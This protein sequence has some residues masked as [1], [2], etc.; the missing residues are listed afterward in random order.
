LS[1]ALPPRHSAFAS[2]FF[3]SVP[4]IRIFS[5]LHFRD[6]DSRLQHLDHLSPLLAGAD[7]LVFNGDLLDTQLARTRHHLDEVRAFFSRLPA[8]VTFLSGNHDPDISD[9]TELFLQGGRVWI[10]H[11]DVLFDDI[12]PWSSQRATLSARLSRLT[13][14]TPPSNDPL[15]D[16]LRR[17]RLACVGLPEHS[18]RHRRGTLVR[19]SK[20]AR[21]FFPPTRPCEMFRAWVRTPSIARRLA[22]AHRP[23][24]RLVVLGHTHYPGVWRTKNGPVVVNTGSFGLPF[25]GFFVELRGDQ[26]EVVRLA[27]TKQGFRRGRV[28]AGFSL[29]P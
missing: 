20:I 19:L 29:A 23:A 3:M 15:C 27:K 9:Q 24:A 26:V 2:K 1:S 4:V 17:N 5:D 13:V 14:E 25:G 12:A 10:T 18:D 11:G 22:G 7:H 8:K 16:R 28:V 6:C 21:L